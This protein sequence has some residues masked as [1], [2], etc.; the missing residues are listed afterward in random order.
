[1]HCLKL[2]QQ[3]NGDGEKPKRQTA[4]PVK[5]MSVELANSRTTTTVSL[6]HNQGGILPKE[7]IRVTVWMMIVQ[8]IPII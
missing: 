3:A 8:M 1:M 2:K 4:I 5:N 7:D 6:L